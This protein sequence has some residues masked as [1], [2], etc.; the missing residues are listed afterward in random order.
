MTITTTTIFDDHND[1]A[2]GERQ[3]AD[4]EGCEAEQQQ[5]HMK[6]TLHQKRWTETI[7][8]PQNHDLCATHKKVKLCTCPLKLLCHN[9]GHRKVYT[10]TGGWPFHV[11]VC[12]CIWEG[13]RML[14]RRVP[15]CVVPQNLQ[16]ANVMDSCG[17]SSSLSFLS[18]WNCRRIPNTSERCFAEQSSLDL[19]CCTL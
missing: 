4:Q 13:A 16:S 2:S 18:D 6:K 15:D 14:Y 8:L 19:L 11:S 9:A 12:V 17:L 3:A 5:R 1:N 10:E 7:E